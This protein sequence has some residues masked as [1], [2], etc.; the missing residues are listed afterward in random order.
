M[1][2]SS[3]MCHVSY[4]SLAQIVALSILSVFFLTFTYTIYCTL[5]LTS[6]VGKKKLR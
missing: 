4:L 1:S 3:K 5:M 6:H 2:D